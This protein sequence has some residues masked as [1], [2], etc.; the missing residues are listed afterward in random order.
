MK[1]KSYVYRGQACKEVHALYF[2][3]EL[4]GWPGWGALEQVLGRNC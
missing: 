4:R 2:G 1:N 3:R